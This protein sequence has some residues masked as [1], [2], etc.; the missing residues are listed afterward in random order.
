MTKK[1]NWTFNGNHGNDVAEQEV[2]IFQ[3]Q[4]KKG[5]GSS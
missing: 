5:N 1:Y 4:N 2:D 3:L